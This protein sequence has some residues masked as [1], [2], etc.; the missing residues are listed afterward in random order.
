MA[1]YNGETILYYSCGNGEREK[2]LEK[3]SARQGVKFKTVGEDGFGASIGALF[4]I[5]EY[6]QGGKDETVK[7]GSEANGIPEEIMVMYNFGSKKMDA[8][9]KAIRSSPLGK[10]DLK[11][12]VTDRNVGW[13]LFELYSEIKKEHELTTGSNKDIND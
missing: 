9:L 13:T 10:I 11:A 1:K 6:S 4:G 7:A 3:I 5:G 12:A 8:L 2:E